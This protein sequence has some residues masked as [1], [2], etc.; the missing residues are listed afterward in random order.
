MSCVTYVNTKCD[1]SDS[2]K[3]CGRPK[4]G[5]TLPA[6][7]QAVRVFYCAL[8]P[9]FG[10]S[11]SVPNIILSDASSRA[12]CDACCAGGKNIMFTKREHNMKLPTV[13]ASVNSAC[14]V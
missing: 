1:S 12:A 13:L 2:K 3:G 8:D 9:M 6:E 14:L 4:E 11:Q 10:A 5:R 7:C